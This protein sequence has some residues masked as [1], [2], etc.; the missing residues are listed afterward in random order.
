MSSQDTSDKNYPEMWVFDI[1]RRVYKKD[2]NGRQ[3]GS[4]IWRE[5]WRPV[6]I[7]GETRVSWIDFFGRK[8]PKKGSHGIA[9]SQTE[10]EQAAFI[11]DS[12]KIARLVSQCKDYNTLKKI[13]ELVGYA[14]D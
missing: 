10:I 12:H 2:E 14:E 1:N 7:V 5:H 8:Y 11:N 3:Y 6:K 9:Y 4:P 13:A